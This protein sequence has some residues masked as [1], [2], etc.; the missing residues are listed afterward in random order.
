MH[1]TA[2]SFYI[3]SL[4]ERRKEKKTKELRHT[5]QTNRSHPKSSRRT[6]RSDSDLVRDDITH[7]LTV[8]C[9]MGQG[10][11]L[12]ITSY[13][14]LPPFPLFF[15]KLTRD[16]C[17]TYSCLC[18]ALATEAPGLAHRCIHLIFPELHSCV[19]ARPGESSKSRSHQVYPQLRVVSGGDSGTK[20]AHRVHWTTARW[21]ANAKTKP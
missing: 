13:M 12:S 1:H 20:S 17:P 8:K 7:F 5:N 14:Y 6:I 19:G 16:Y 21:P 10:V 18:I 2:C 9:Q 3:K 4:S 15:I 11:R